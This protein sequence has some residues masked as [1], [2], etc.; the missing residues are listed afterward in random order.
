MERWIPSTTIGS[1]ARTR[2]SVNRDGRLSGTCS[3]GGEPREESKMR[4]L[5]VVVLLIG[6][7]PAFAQAPA[8]PPEPPPRLEASAQFTF[9]DTRGNS[10]SHS[11]GAGGDVTWR[12]DPWTYTAKAIFAQAEDE[13]E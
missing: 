4:L 10:S 3:T 1:S 7:T 5:L 2:K 6:A 13:G 8:P 9:L 12:P 11:L